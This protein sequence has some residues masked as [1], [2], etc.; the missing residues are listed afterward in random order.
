[1]SCQQ[2]GQLFQ[3]L[4][5]VNHSFTH[6][7]VCSQLSVFFVICSFIFWRTSHVT[8]LKSFSIIKLIFFTTSHKL[9][10][11][12][13]VKPS[14]SIFFTIIFEE[15]KLFI[16]NL[17]ASIFCWIT[18]SVSVI[19]KSKKAFIFS[20][21]FSLLKYGGASFGSSDFHKVNFFLNASM[22]VIDFTASSQS[23]KSVKFSLFQCVTSTQVIKCLCMKS[24]SNT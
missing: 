11:N 8:F 12:F 14:I 22:S 6:Q 24:L 19:F 5:S 10:K 23:M 13:G 7:S 21:S 2:K 4:C 3:I 1:M 16:F 17:F 15:L 9:I 18:S 20:L